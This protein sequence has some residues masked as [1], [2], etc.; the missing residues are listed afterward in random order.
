MEVIT[1]LC[2]IFSTLT[3]PSSAGSS[4]QYTNQQPNLIQNGQQLFAKAT[5]IK[6]KTAAEVAAKAL[7]TVG[8][9][10]QQILSPAST[11]A[12]ETPQSQ[13]KHRILSADPQSLLMTQQGANGG[14]INILPN[15]QRYFKAY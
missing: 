1:Q 5:I 7:P 10:Q 3:S 11:I 8:H 12:S 15:F 4:A 2:S 6:P 13:G 14:K 9:F